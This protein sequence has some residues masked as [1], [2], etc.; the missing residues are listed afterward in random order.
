M[1]SELPFEI[2]SFVITPKENMLKAEWTLELED[3]RP[4][5][6]ESIEC[7]SNSI[8]KEINKQIVS[9]FYD[10]ERNCDFWKNDKIV[11]T[12][13]PDILTGMNSIFDSLD[14]KETRCNCNGQ[15]KMKTEELATIIYDCCNEDIRDSI[16]NI[17]T[18]IMAKCGCILSDEC[19]EQMKESLRRYRNS[20]QGL[21]KTAE[22][23]NS[24]IPGTNDE[25]DAFSF[26]LFRR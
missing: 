9:A 18:K 5:L 24:L 6:E 23:I 13:S 11:P 4:D 19:I 3:E 14:Q 12:D 2:E 17:A 1:K 10:S 15:C 20:G 8:L 21:E 16:T 22:E 7:M 25:L 26:D